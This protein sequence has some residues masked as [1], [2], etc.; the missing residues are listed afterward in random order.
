MKCKQTFIGI[1]LCWLLAFAPF[2][3]AANIFT[4]E[5]NGRLGSSLTGNDFGQ[6]TNF[7]VVSTQHVTNVS[8]FLTVNGGAPFVVGDANFKDIGDNPATYFEPGN[9]QTYNADNEYT[10]VIRRNDNTLV[11]G[12][13]VRLR[14][15]SR[16][17]SGMVSWEPTMQITNDSPNPI[18]LEAMR[19]TQGNG[20]V[21]FS[22]IDTIAG[23]M[24]DIAR[25]SYSGR[26]YI[27][28]FGLTTSRQLDKDGDLLTQ[29]NAGGPGFVL[30][31]IVANKDAPAESAFITEPFT[32]PPGGR[33]ITNYTQNVNVVGVVN[34]EPIGVSVNFTAVGTSGDGNAGGLVIGGELTGPPL[35]GVENVQLP[36]ARVS[37]VRRWS[38]A[39]TIGSGATADITFT[40]DPATDGIS[41][42]DTLELA[43]RNLLTSEWVEWN[44][45]VRTPAADTITAV[46]ITQDE[47]NGMWILASTGDNS[48]PVF[49]S[50]FTAEWNGMSV[51]LNWRT[52]WETNNLGFS[53]YRGRTAEGP[54]E[55]IGFVD[56]T[57]S[58]HHTGYKFSDDS[59]APE[60]I[61]W[62]YIEDVDLSGKTKKSRLIE[63]TADK[64]SIKT[65]LIPPQFAL[66]QNYP[67]PF[68]PETWIPYELA[69]DAPV[70][71]AIYDV[72]GQ[73]IRQ[74]NFGKREPGSYL[75]KQKAAYWDGKDRLGQVVSSG[76]YFYSLKAGAFQATRRLVIQK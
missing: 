4:T 46:G 24:D 64:Q 8:Y 11:I 9:F 7:T 42:E 65:H 59:V 69:V 21:T 20:N 57:G 43:T 52:E 26:V 63:V 17:S 1:M 75:T 3:F 56:S 55:K 23:S 34:L 5:G 72:K 51:S 25:Y 60:H 73:L 76:V 18:T 48:L 15:P 38:F 13:G 58:E 19:Y 44:N 71:I 68:N 67:N 31:N 27:D 36:L 37:A 62:Y 61:Y 45:I 41:D 50:S 12:F 35:G 39:T 32:I 28:P 47:L 49:L 14:D 22:N 53:I 10:N 16:S 66:L 54:F 6:V 30:N 40:Y 29:I 70:T 74:L 33:I 2:G